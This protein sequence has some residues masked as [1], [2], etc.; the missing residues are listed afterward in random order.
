MPSKTNF[1]A[2]SLGPPA[3]KAD[4]GRLSVRRSWSG[5]FLG[6]QRIT[7]NPTSKVA[8]TAKPIYRPHRE[9]VP[10]VQGFT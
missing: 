1:H 7:V 2:P 5:R 3:D 9:L 4:R 8:F 6:P 10:H